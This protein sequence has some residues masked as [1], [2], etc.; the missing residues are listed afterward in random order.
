[1]IGS[2]IRILLARTAVGFGL[3][4]LVIYKKGTYISYKTVNMKLG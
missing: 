2:G 4:L 1:M 3:K